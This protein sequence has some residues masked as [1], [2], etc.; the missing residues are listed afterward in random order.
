M[1]KQVARVRRLLT[2]GLEEDMS[3]HEFCAQINACAPSCFQ[4]QECSC[5]FGCKGWACKR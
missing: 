1:H 4:A 3:C 5:C 2:L